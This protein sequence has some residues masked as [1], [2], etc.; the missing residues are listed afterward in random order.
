ML[1]LPAVFPGVLASKDSQEPLHHCGDRHWR[2][3]KQ[4]AQL[5][6]RGLGLVQREEGKARAPKEGA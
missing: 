5:L 4:A 3:L 6:P 2:A 1:R